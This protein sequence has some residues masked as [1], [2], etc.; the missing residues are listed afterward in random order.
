ML[1]V[2]CPIYNEEKYIAKCIDSIIAQ[3]YPKD[4]L[5]VIFADGMSTDKTR[6]IVK[7]YIDK[8]PWIKLIDNPDRIVSPGLNKAIEASK[9]DI[10]MR[11]DAHAE[12]PD[13][14]LSELSSQLI[15]LKA[16]NVGGVCVTLPLN[17]SATAKAIA[18]VLSSKFGMGNSDFRVGTDKIKKVDT[19][20]FGCW[21]RSVFEKIGYFDLDLIRNQDDEFN[22]RLINAGEDIYLLPHIKIKYFAR[23]KISKVAK[24][25]YQYGLFKPLVNK[26]LGKPATIRQ[27][28]PLVL[29]LGIIIGLIISILWIPFAFIYGIGIIFY[30][31]LCLI[32]SILSKG[33][34]K[35]I[36]LQSFTYMV[37]HFSYGFGYLAGLWKLLLKKDFNAKSNR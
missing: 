37:V 17:Q 32:A 24:M 33:N 2:I 28:A 11:I 35:Q 34:F 5:E 18:N 26:K 29:V 4:D 21:T 20:P 14:Y 27:F 22:G 7:E 9:G 15:K 16:G 19:V 8:Y 23:D 1:S 6:E 3:D 36:I 10:I 13:N 25:F 31:M 30:M 12:Y